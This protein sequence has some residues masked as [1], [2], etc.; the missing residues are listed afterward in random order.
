[1]APPAAGVEWVNIFTP[2]SLALEAG[3]HHLDP[4]QARAV[5]EL[6]QQAWPLEVEKPR[7]Q[8]FIVKNLFDP[9]ASS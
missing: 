6:L 8:G 7:Q 3:A 2:R 9:V 5:D 1:M 4:F